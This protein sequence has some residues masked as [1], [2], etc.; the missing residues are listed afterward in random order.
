MK[1]K[2]AKISNKYMKISAGKWLI[3]INRIKNKSFCL[4]NIYVFTVYI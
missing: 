4:Q 3:V 1:S 2:G